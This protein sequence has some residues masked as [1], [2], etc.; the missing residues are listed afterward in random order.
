VQMRQVATNHLTLLVVPGTLADTVARV[1][2]RLA[3]GGLRTEIGTPDLIPCPNALREQLTI[4]IRPGETSQIRALTLAY[5]GHKERHRWRR[6]FFLLGL[7]LLGYAAGD[8][9]SQ[10]RRRAE[11]AVDE[12]PHIGLRVSQTITIS[13]CQFF[14][15][16]SSNRT[17]RPR[18]RL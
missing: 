12:G 8:E 15:K 1:D 11:R 13:G 2:G 17:S 7:R 18:T 4:L 9:E 16:S 5:A 6:S 3:V 14:A 10:N